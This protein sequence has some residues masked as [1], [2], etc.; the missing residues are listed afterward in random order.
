MPVGREGQ[1]P[2][3]GGVDITVEGG[4]VVLVESLDVGGFT[5]GLAHLRRQ[6]RER[7][8]VGGQQAAIRDA[9]GLGDA[10]GQGFGIRRR[11]W[12]GFIGPRV[13]EQGRVVPQRH[14]VF[15]PLQRDV[16]AR[17]RLARVPLAL[18]AVHD[19]AA[20][21]PLAQLLGERVCELPLVVAVGV[22]VP[23]GGRRIIDRD[24]R[25]LAAHGQ[26]HIRGGQP[27][28]DGLAE[29]VDALPLRVGVGAGRAGVLVDAAHLVVEREL[30]LDSLGST[31]DGGSR[32]GFGCGAQRNVALAREQAARGIQSDP[33]GAGHVDLSPGVQVGE[34]GGWPAGPVERRLVGGE[35]DEVAR[36]KARGQTV[37]TQQADEQPRAVAA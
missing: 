31:R 3:G 33:A 9:E 11:A 34:V 13:G 30:H 36:D 21:V 7:V 8:F 25:R 15:A 14:P 2:A 17:Q 16:P 5:G 20:R 29:L 32:R 23:F 26:A 12:L 10:P 27:F 4:K 19:A 22:G 28:I 1:D 6:R 37:L 18:A 24:E 35:L